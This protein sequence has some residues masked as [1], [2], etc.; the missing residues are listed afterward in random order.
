MSEADGPLCHFMHGI[1]VAQTRAG[2]DH[3]SVRPRRTTLVGGGEYSNRGN[4]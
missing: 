3:P 2:E 1:E 4:M